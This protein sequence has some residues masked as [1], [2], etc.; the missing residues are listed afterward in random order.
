MTRAAML[1]ALIVGIAMQ[2]AAAEPF[3]REDLRIPMETAGT[4]GLEA[5]AAARAASA[6]ICVR[7]GSRPAI[8]ARR[9]RP[10]VAGPTFRPM[11]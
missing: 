5:R 10:W 3:Y 11:A 7:L 8:C 9:S 1:A 4:R 2:P 6:N